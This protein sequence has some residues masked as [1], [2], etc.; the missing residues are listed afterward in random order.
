M[1]SQLIAHLMTLLISRNPLQANGP[2][3][4]RLDLEGG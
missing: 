1:A 4:I 2:H 3:Q